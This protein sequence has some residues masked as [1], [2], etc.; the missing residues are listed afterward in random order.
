MNALVVRMEAVTASFRYPRV[1]VGKV[2]TFDMPPPA[3]IYGHLACVLGEWF[4][5]AGLEFSYVFRHAGKAFDLE[6]GHPIELGSGRPT[7][8]LAK[9]GWD[10][11]VNV[12]CEANPARREF[13][14]RPTMTLYLTGPDPLIG[15]LRASFL[16]P[17]FTYILG[18]SQ[19]LAMC[20][21]ADFVEL[22]ES[23]EAYFSHTLL[24]YAW[25]PYILSGTSVALPC[26]INYKQGRAA[27]QDRY[28]Q[29]TSPA[30]HVYEGS[31]DTIARD[32]LPESFAVDRTDA[33]QSGG[34]SLPRGIQFFPVRWELP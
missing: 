33:I 24:P 22:T 19:D 34:R 15:R 17:Y 28:V 31:R 10:H 27:A 8:R 1:Q 30:L 5:P 6:T 21:S 16:S 20:H 9:R 25:R 14:L 3:T 13:L 18:R 2:P 26:A 32:R 23:G 11:P 4:D 12:E 7:P 29:V